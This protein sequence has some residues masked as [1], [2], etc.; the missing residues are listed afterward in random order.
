LER[1]CR[2]PNCNIILSPEKGKTQK[3]PLDESKTPHPIELQDSLEVQIYKMKN[4]LRVAGVLILLTGIPLLLTL[5]LLSFTG[6]LLIIL[7]LYF[8]LR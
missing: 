6:M 4:K 5:S 8:I 1:Y 7:G 2:C 3:D